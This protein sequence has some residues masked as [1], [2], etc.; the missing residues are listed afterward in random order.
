MRKDFEH[1]Q[2]LPRVSPD[3]DSQKPRLLNPGKVRELEPVEIPRRQPPENSGYGGAG[4]IPPGDNTGINGMNNMSGMNVNVPGHLPQKERQGGR[5]KMIALLVAGFV[6]AAFCGAALSGYLS[7]QQAKKAAM[8]SQH[9][10]ATQQLQEAD[11]QQES[12]SRKKEQLEA[13]Y[14][15]LLE[16][17]VNDN[18][19]DNLN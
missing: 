13:E 17:K 15:R 8:D 16:D 11:S 2:P 4:N 1:T 18:D 6:L 19:N 9:A 7:E 12:L 3:M 5:G 14:Q 10:A